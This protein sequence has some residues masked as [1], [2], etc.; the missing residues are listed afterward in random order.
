MQLLNHVRTTPKNA[1]SITEGKF[2]TVQ[3]IIECL[4]EER[5]DSKQKDT[6]DRSLKSYLIGD[7]ENKLRNQLNAFL[8]FKV[9]EESEQLSLVH[10]A[11]VLIDSNI[12]FVE[13]GKEFRALEPF[14]MGLSL[15]K[16]K[17]VQSQLSFFISGDPSSASIEAQLYSG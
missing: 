11:F 1:L 5:F 2:K 8:T 13:M 14:L 6:L 7:S 4:D 12:N 9:K 16:L 17:E 15:K 10:L 3:L